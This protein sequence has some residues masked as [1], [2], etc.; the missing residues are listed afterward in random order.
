MP[1]AVLVLVIFGFGDL[2]LLFAVLGLFDCFMLF[3]FICL[4]CF[5]FGIVCYC[6]G[7]SWIFWIWCLLN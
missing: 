4:C 6:F 5:A 1:L 7:C 2:C 3:V